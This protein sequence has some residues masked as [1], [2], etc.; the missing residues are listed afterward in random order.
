[1][2]SRIARRADTQATIP[3]RQALKYLL[4]VPAFGVLAGCDALP[5]NP[6]AGGSTDG[7]D[8][9][10]EVRD[11]LRR[12]ALTATLVVDITS[13]GDEVR[14]TG[15]VPNQSDFYNIEDV[16]GQ[17]PGVRIAIVDVYWQK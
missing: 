4:A 9:S 5:R 10:L 17:V 7:K 15:N 2:N 1:M 11:A 12:H 13:R 8:L 14:I 16:A 6:N 3:R